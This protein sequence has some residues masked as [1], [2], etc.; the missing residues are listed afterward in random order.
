MVITSSPS[1]HQNSHCHSHPVA[2]AFISSSLSR[3]SAKP[4]KHHSSAILFQCGLSLGL[5]SASR[6]GR[7]T[8]CRHRSSAS[9]SPSSL[10][11]VI[12]M[13]ISGASTAIWPATLAI[14]HLVE[15]QHPLRHL[16]VDT[17]WNRH[18]RQSHLLRPHPI[19]SLQWS[20]RQPFVL[21]SSLTRQDI[22]LSCSSPSKRGQGLEQGCSPQPKLT[23]SVCT[24]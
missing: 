14:A 20:Q 21:L 9:P 8:C 12:A 3:P 13:R 18:Q 1:W 4:S 2:V 19:S 6:H 24:L 5:Q 22:F 16:R 10:H 11:H 23:L 7:N 15:V 17:A